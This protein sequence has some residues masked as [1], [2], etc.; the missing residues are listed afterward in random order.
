M[1]SKYLAKL[2]NHKKSLAAFGGVAALFAQVFSDGQLTQGEVEKLGTTA[3]AA[4]FVYLLPNKPV[5]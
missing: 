5:A 3:V 2:N 4:L 1:L